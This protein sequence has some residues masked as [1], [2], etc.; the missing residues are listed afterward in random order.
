MDLKR[1]IWQRAQQK[2]DGYENKY[3]RMAKAMLNKEF[4]TLA[5]HI[6]V[7]NFRSESVF[8]YMSSEPIKKYYKDLYRTVGVAFAKDVY[9]TVKAESI[10]LTKGEDDLEDVWGQHMENYVKTRA[11]NRIVSIAEQNIVQAKKIIRGVLDQSNT[12]GW[13]SDETARA[14]RKG[15]TEDAIEMNQW[16]A[17][18]IART[19]IVSA[20]NQGSH[21]GAQSLDMP[22]NKYWIS[23]KDSRTRDTHIG[24][25]AQNPKD[26]EEPFD[27]GGNPGQYPGDP[28]LPAEEVINCRCT[29]GYEVK[30]L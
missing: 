8:N 26:M 19:E 27:V 18:R 25:E 23:V 9:K 3:Y 6:D 1:I 10:H 24:M 12:E 28:E 2:R 5:E 30:G 13:G 22:M 21:L 16:R 14:I 15:L 29:V 11:G 17:L 4:R 20:S 7:T